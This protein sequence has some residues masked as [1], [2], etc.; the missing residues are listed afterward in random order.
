M[1]W[2]PV[3]PPF[4]PLPNGAATKTNGNLCTVLA[5]ADEGER[6]MIPVSP[7]MTFSERQLEPMQSRIEKLR[8]SKIE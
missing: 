4:S 2:L 6:D 1:A 3:H 8:D 5:H 7:S